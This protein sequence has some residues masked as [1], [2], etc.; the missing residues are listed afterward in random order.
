MPCPNKCGA[1]PER[2]HVEKHVNTEC[3]LTVVDCDFC[4]IGCDVQL[5]HKEMSAHMQE[6][7]FRH[8]TLLALHNQKLAE[9]NLKLH[10][11]MVEKDEQLVKFKNDLKKEMDELEENNL[12]L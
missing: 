1:I 7:S 11:K 3:P 6:N 4:Y 9:E 2:Q 5:T 12:A 10:R 8:I